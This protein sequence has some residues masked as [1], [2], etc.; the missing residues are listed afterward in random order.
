MYW[1]V[2]VA[3]V[4]DPHQHADHGNGFGEE[5]AKLI[6]LLLQGCHLIIR[7]CHGMPAASHGLTFPLP[8][9]LLLLLLVLLFLWP[10]EVLMLQDDCAI[11]HNSL[12]T[13]HES[14]PCVLPGY[15]RAKLSVQHL[16]SHFLVSLAVCL[17][18]LT[19]YILAL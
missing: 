11:R 7:L 1:V 4:D 17:I 13:T 5:G 6:Q 9:L 15:T 19:Q 16:T 12:G 14:S 8:L 3:N 2:K 10:T 18:A